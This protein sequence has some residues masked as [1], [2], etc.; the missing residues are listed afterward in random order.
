MPDVFPATPA[1]RF[2]LAKIVFG[3]ARGE[4]PLGQLG[5]AWTVRSRAERVLQGIGEPEFGD[6]TLEGAAFARW[7]Y[8]CTN[9]SGI[10]AAIMAVQSLNSLDP[11]WRR[12]LARA[13]QVISGVPDPTGGALW[14]YDVSMGWP[15]AWG[16]PQS[17]DYTVGRLRFF[18]HLGQEGLPRVTI[19]V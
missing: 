14:Y 1:G 11:T 19:S 5:V 17:P 4:G 18:R 6:G 2:A 13:D 15:R 9:P 12:C 16:P 7:Q 3:E 8:S 10:E